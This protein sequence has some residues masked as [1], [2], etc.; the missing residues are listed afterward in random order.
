MTATAKGGDVMSNQPDKKQLCVPPE[1]A[2]HRCIFTAW[3][4]HPDLWLDDLGPARAE[5]AG[6]IKCLAEGETIKVLTCGEE[7]RRSAEAAVGNVAQVFPAAF[8]DIWVRD[9]GPIFVSLAGQECAVRFRNNGWGLK[10]N[11]PHDDT[12]GD[13]IAELAGAVTLH[14]DFVLEGGAIEHNG[15]GWVLTTRQCLLNPNRN[16]GWTEQDAEQALARSLGCVRVLWLDQGLANDHTDGHIDNLVR[17]IGAD[18][19]VCQHPAGADDPNADLYVAIAVRLASMGL[20]VCTIPSPGLVCSEEGDVMPAS[21][22][23]FIIGNKTI[24]VPVYGTDSAQTAVESLAGLFPDHK[25]MGLPSRALL[26]GG[27]SFHCIT[28]QVPVL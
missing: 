10:Y 27:G 25:V 16:R 3:P 23:N 26:T 9:T 8:G 14:H 28:Q 17:F 7:S 24:A 18:T 12:V 13:E 20:Q 22:M 1:W 5:V 15:A 19:V 2:K 21:H 11:L 6:M 4:S